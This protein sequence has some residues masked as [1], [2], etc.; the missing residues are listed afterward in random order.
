MKPCMQ[1]KTKYWPTSANKYAEALKETFE[2]DIKALKNMLANKNTYLD[3]SKEAMLK[4]A[5]VVKE[6][7]VAIKEYK[8]IASKTSTVT[9]KRS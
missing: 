6:C 3:A 1:W 2:G 7:N 5:S 4:A 9:S 8:Q